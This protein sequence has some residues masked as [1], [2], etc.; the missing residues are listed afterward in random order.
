VSTRGIVARQ[1]GPLGE[2]AFRKTILPRNYAAS[3]VGQPIACFASQWCVERVAMVR[4]KRVDI[5]PRDRH[6]SDAV[7]ALF[8]LCFSLVRA[9]R[10]AVDTPPGVG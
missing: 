6:L 5:P 9:G 4:R 8:V 10:S 7:F 1:S 2:N 3:S